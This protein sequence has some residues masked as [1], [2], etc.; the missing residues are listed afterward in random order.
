MN[1]N[2]PSRLWCEVARIV[3]DHCHR[4]DVRR[5]P[6][7]SMPTRQPKRLAVVALLVSLVMTGQPSSADDSVAVDRLEDDVDVGPVETHGTWHFRGGLYAHW[8]GSD[9]FKGPHI[10]VSI[11]RYR[12]DNWIYG[13]ALFNNSFDQFS[14][15]YFTGRKWHPFQKRPNLDLKLT[16]GLVHGYEGEHYDT[17]PVRWGGSWGLGVVPSLGHKKDK[18][19]YEVSVL[20]AGGLLFSIGRDL[21]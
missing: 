14:Q 3:L 6:V 2:L 13:L 19:N 5:R 7:K 1:S 9:E 10:L 21:N 8:N 18:T 17:L 20:G 12:S 11:E 15:Y 16:V 4:S